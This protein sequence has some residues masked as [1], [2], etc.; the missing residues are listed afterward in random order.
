MKTKKGYF[1]KNKFDATCYLLIT[2]IYPI[3]T[4]SIQLHQSNNDIQSLFDIVI[5]GLFFSLT[6]YYDYYSR[7]RDCHNQLRNVVKIFLWGCVIFFILS[8]F[9]ICSIF[10]L[11][12]GIG[13]STIRIICKVIPV[14]VCYPFI[15]SFTELTRRIY[16]E[17][18]GKITNI[19]V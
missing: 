5:S 17:Y 12:K 1:F 3:F 2:V 13:I 18:R 6:Y 16:N 9:M 4:Y 10:L 19:K 11:A 14:F 15:M 7:F 8:V